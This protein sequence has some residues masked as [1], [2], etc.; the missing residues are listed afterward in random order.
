MKN[1]NILCRGGCFMTWELEEIDGLAAWPSAFFAL[2]V[3]CYTSQKG[4]RRRS[5]F[6]FWGGGVRKQLCDCLPQ[7]VCTRTEDTHLSH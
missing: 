5:S 7:F 2:F 1:W 3:Q 6:I 4:P